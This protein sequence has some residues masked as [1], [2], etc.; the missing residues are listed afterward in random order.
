[1]QTNCIT[2]LPAAYVVFV[3]ILKHMDNMHHHTTPSQQKLK[4]FVSYPTHENK[5]DAPPDRR[6]SAPGRG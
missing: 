4:L 1:M 3:Q 5:S 6:V 2:N